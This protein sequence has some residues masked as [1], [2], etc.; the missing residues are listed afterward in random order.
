MQVWE[1][2][3]TVFAFYTLR[4]TSYTVYEI[5]VSMYVLINTNA[6]QFCS[7]GRKE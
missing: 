7:S 6:L 2:R 4:S 3:I 1:G 5:T